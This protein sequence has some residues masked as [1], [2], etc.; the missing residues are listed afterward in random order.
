MQRV[1][2]AEVDEMW[3]CVGNKAQQGWLWHAIEHLSG[4]VLASAFG[5]RADAVFV[6]L[7]KW[8]NPFGLVHFYPAGA[9]LS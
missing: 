8:L 9:L 2:A 5:S 6:E 1:E 7:K 3:S 4:V